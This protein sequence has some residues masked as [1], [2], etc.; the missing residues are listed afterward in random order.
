MH[1]RQ[2]AREINASYEK[3]VQENVRLTKEKDGLN[4]LTHIEKLARE[5]LGMVK[6][7]EI[8]YISPKKQE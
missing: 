3:A 4:T 6:P 7:G 2:E 5:E 8:P 1:I